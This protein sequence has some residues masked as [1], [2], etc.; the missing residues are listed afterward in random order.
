MRE[1]RLY[2]PEPAVIVQVDG[3][4]HD[5]TNQ[6]SSWN[7]YTTNKYKSN[8]NFDQHSI[9]TD[10]KLVNLTAKD[11]H[12]MVGSPAIDHGTSVGLTRDYDG[13]TIPSGSGPD[14]GVDEY[15]SAQPVCGNGIV[16]GTEQ[17][18]GTG[19][20]SQT[21]QTQGFT[22]GTLNCNNDC[23]FNTGACT[24]CTPNCT[25]KTCGSDGCGG[26]CGTCSA[27][28]TCQSGTCK[29]LCGNGAID[30]GE[31][32]D[33]SNLNSQTCVS[34][35]G[36]SWTGTLVCNSDCTINSS[37]CV[38]V[39]NGTCGTAGGTNTYTAPTANLCS[40]GTASTV[41]L[42]SNVFSWTCAGSNTGKDATCSANQ[43]VDGGWSVWSACSVTCG[44]GTQTRTCIN[45][46]PLNGGTACSG[47]ASRSCTVTAP[48][49]YRDSDKDYWGYS[50]S[51]KTS[52][53][54]PTTITVGG[55]TVKYVTISSVRYVDNVKDCCD[56]VSSTCSTAVSCS[57]SCFT[58]S[59]K[60]C[61]K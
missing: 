56:S 29:A 12:L 8:Q 46:A 60:A 2:S 6:A 38:Q 50:G 24:S 42:N 17:C 30:S 23:T 45:P 41:A 43:K 49:Y 26:S 44:T 5:Y 21:C 35:K 39:V 52:C 22:G 15:V 58:K 25:G 28:Q 36:T 1:T 32:C 27:S 33:G 55:A 48:T 40:A 13:D 37:D 57:Y 10:P 34:V 14:I 59:T 51:K 61:H 19:L 7:T 47:S 4:G 11:F 16:E 18:D 20:N 3:Y 31:Q 54:T 53:N 9:I